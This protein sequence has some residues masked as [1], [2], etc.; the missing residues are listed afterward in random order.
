MEKHTGVN[1]VQEEPTQNMETA[2]Q[3]AVV[4]H[5]KHNTNFHI[6]LYFG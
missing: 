1:H 3:K 5:I 2:G 4:I 6:I